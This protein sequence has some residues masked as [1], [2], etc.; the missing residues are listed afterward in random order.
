MRHFEHSRRPAAGTKIAATVSVARH[1]PTEDTAIEH[2]DD[3]FLVLAVD[4]DPSI[5]DLAEACLAADDLMIKVACDGRGCVDSL[6]RFLPDCV[7]LDLNLPDTSGLELLKSIKAHQPRLPVIMLTADVAVDTVVSA[8]QAGAWDYLPKPLDCTK[9]NAT[10]RNAIAQH[11]LEVR[12]SQLEREARGGGYGGI[13]A[14]AESMK[15]LFRQ[16]DRVSAS[17]V[18]VLL[19]GESGTGKELVARALHQTG[20]RSR[21]PFVEINCAAIPESLAASELFGHERGAFTGADQRRIGRLEQADGGT[22]FLDE[23]AEL[24][25]SLQA[26]L[27]RALQERRFQRVGGNQEITPDFRLIAATHRQLE[28]EVAARRFRE[29]LFFRIAVFEL[30]LPPLRERDDDA[31]LLAEHFLPDDLRLA[32]A[33]R[34]MFLAYPWPGNVRE[35]QNAIEH[36]SV[37]ATGGTVRRDDLPRRIR[38]HPSVQPGA[39]AAADEAPGS[40]AEVGAGGADFEIVGTLDELESAAIRAA[41]TRTDGNL[42]EACRMLGI[43]RTTLYR[44]LERYGI[45]RPGAGEAS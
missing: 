1:R 14:A 11:R 43:G 22:L 4:D 5:C 42:S 13:V 39:E 10:V 28:D 26:K 44:K 36:A 34:Q 15:R 41:I 25:L 40:A 35:L 6:A 31:L 20:S 9:L 17:D 37:V 3:H 18:T 33:V 8:M 24:D 21:G 29:D 45:A 38:N 7:L 27:L 30:E 2:H 16:M 23:V 32:S 12:V 19:H